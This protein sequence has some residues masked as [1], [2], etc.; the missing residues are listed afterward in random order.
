RLTIASGGRRGSDT[1]G[2]RRLGEE[3]LVHGHVQVPFAATHARGRPTE[4]HTDR[5]VRG[6]VDDRELGG[7][8]AVGRAQSWHAVDHLPRD[9]RT[10]AR[11]LHAEVA[12]LHVVAGLAAPL[13][14]ELRR[15][16]VVQLAQD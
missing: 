15:A 3:T 16:V 10:L 2:V 12:V 11:P 5:I 4:E 6:V 9:L 13:V 8:A 1:G 7:E 14:Y